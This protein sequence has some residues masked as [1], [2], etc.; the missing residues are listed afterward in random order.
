MSPVPADQTLIV[1]NALADRSVALPLPDS[2]RRI[3]LPGATA[4]LPSSAARL[5]LIRSLVAYGVIRQVSGPALGLACHEGKRQ[6]LLLQLVLPPEL[7]AAEARAM[8]GGSGRAG[9]RPPPALTAELSTSPHLRRLRLQPLKIGAK[10]AYT[11]LAEIVAAQGLKP[12]F[13]FALLDGRI[14]LP[15]RFGSA[16]SSPR[17]RRMRPQRPARC[18]AIGAGTVVMR[19]HAIC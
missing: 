8:A 3:L 16:G 11:L 18:V 9:A 2:N 15:L 17:R 6:A 14:A 13:L 5:P 19:Q 12:D 10:A 1:R 4:S 7:A